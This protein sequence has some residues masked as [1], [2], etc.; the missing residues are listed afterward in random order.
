[1][2]APDQSHLD[3]PPLHVL[4]R[5]ARAGTPEP[6]QRHLQVPG[7]D[8]EPVPLDVSPASQDPVDGP[9]GVAA[10]LVEPAAGQLAGV[11]KDP[12]ELLRG[13]PRDRLVRERD[14]DPAV[15]GAAALLRELPPFAA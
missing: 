8:L 13:D 10:G 4:D 3:E 11:A 15:A 9:G 12:L 2:R 6:L 7:G 5:P 14:A 1:V